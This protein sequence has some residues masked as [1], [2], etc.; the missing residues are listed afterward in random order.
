MVSHTNSWPTTPRGNGIGCGILIRC[1]WK[2]PPV[3]QFKA[4]GLVKMAMEIE[5]CKIFPATPCSRKYDFRPPMRNIICVINTSEEKPSLR[6]K[7]SL[8]WTRLDWETE[9]LLLY[10]DFWVVEQQTEA[11][12]DTYICYG[13]G[14][15]LTTASRILTE[16]RIQA[17]ISQNDKR[18]FSQSH[19]SSRAK[20]VKTRA[21]W[22]AWWLA[23]A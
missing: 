23:L 8:F 5:S 21:V 7:Q 19:L 10:L 20:K 2:T 18:R 15:K 6:Y 1:L 17:A 11:G 9:E 12:G 22:H 4:Q 3:V 13:I 16:F 14:Y